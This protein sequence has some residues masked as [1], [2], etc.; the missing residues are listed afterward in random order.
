[1]A[2]YR[3][4]EAHYVNGQYYEPGEV[5]STADVPGGT[6]PLDWVPSAQVDPLDA[7]AI[8]AYWEAGPQT[9]NP[10]KQR[11]VGH[12]VGTPRIYWQPARN[13]RFRAAGYFELTGDGAAFGPQIGH[14][15]TRL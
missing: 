10:T 15:G 6:L 4:F 3:F 11:W 14:R 8:R 9:L 1:M 12:P 5:A 13:P 7:S 2:T